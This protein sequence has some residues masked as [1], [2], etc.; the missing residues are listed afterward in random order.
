MMLERLR[1]AE[2][3]GISHIETVASIQAYDSRIQKILGQTIHLPSIGKLTTGIIEP[4][5]QRLHLILLDDPYELFT[6]VIE[7]QR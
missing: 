4:F 5:P 2:I 7:I 6:A 3:R 1:K